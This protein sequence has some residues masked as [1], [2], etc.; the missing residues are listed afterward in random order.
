MGKI[1]KWYGNCLVFK[2]ILSLGWFATEKSYFLN[3]LSVVK[4]I[5]MSKFAQICINLWFLMVKTAQEKESDSQHKFSL[6][7]SW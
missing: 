4:T 6:Q 7:F 5:N 1:L 2:N 3:V